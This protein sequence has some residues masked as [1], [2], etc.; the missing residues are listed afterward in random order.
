MVSSKE[1]VLE[2]EETFE[3]FEKKLF[4]KYREKLKEH[5]KTS[6]NID[7]QEITDD[8]LLSSLVLIRSYYS[9]ESLNKLTKVL[10]FFTIALVLFTIVLA[11]LTYLLY[12]KVNSSY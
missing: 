7:V 6:D 3:E 10:I 11:F 12:L 9:Q 5:L 4:K 1:S 8:N 2:S